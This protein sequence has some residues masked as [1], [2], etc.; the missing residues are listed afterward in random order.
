MSYCQQCADTE[1]E[2]AQ[3]KA[4]RDGA[5]LALKSTQQG[6]E[7]VTAALTAERERSKRLE[8]A[9]R[10]I[11]DQY[12]N[13]MWNCRVCDPNGSGRCS[14]HKAEALDAVWDNARAALSPSTPKE[15][16]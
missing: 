3:V 13:Q 7:T 8:E 1:R 2:L 9:L 14:R 15:P 4:E 16:T 12:D 10:A 11:V 5:R 6:W